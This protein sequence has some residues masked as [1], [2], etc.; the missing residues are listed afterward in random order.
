MSVSE[1]CFSIVQIAYQGIPISSDGELT[2]I[3]VTG[4]TCS[5]NS[6]HFYDLIGAGLY[7]TSSLEK[8]FNG[9]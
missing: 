9:Q 6:Y 8:P 7:T 1:S 3:M 2:G 5:K 4:N